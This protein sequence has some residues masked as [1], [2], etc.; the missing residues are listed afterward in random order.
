VEVVYEC[1]NIA[2]SAIFASQFQTY[3]DENISPTSTPRR[4]VNVRGEFAIR[5]DDESMVTKLDQGGEDQ[6]VKYAT[7]ATHRYIPSAN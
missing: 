7:V 3:Q 2:G 5:Y 6:A 1:P 4:R